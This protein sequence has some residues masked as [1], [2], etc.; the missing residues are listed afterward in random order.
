MADAVEESDA[1]DSQ[2]GH[3]VSHLT[4]QETLP[5]DNNQWTRIF[6]R[7]TGSG[8]RSAIFPIGQDLIYD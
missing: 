5:K 3:L 6:S 2:Y 4:K 8:L 1:S 7:D